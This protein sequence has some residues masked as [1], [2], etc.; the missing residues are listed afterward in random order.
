MPR[1]AFAAW[2]GQMYGTK[3][4]F[5]INERGSLHIM[6]GNDAVGR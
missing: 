3:P 6:S 4:W 2:R 5:E 1:T